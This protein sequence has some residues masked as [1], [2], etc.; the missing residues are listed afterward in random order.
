M[1]YGRCFAISHTPVFNRITYGGSRCLLRRRFTMK[2]ISWKVSNNDLFEKARR[3][4]GHATR[5]KLNARPSG[6]IFQPLQAGMLAIH[7]R[8]KHALDPINI[9]N[10]ARLYKEL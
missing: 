10:P 4:G 6:E 9:L 7:K 3:L 1:I 2:T 8:I 5:Y